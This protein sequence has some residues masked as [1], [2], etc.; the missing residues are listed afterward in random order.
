[1]KK[2]VIWNAIGTT[3]NSFNSL[4]FM[5]IVTRMNGIDQS[6][7]FTMA[8]SLAC[9]FCIFAGYEGRVYQVTDVNADFSD[10]NNSSSVISFKINSKKFLFTGDIDSSVEKRLIEENKDLNAD[11]LKVSH[12]GSKYSTS[13][14]FL[15][16]VNP[17]VAVISVGEKNYYKHPSNETLDRLKNK[18]IKI[19]RTDLENTI[20]IKV[21]GKLWLV[22]KK[23]LIIFV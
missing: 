20:I 17:D 9:L 11:I 12:H 21:W 15:D 1:M 16:A 18:N 2:N 7:V 10:S 14:E 4:F 3:F 22:Q 19:M 13:N 8:F 23:S 5:I 6:G